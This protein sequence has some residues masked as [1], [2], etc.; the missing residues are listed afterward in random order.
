MYTDLIVDE[1]DPLPERLKE[2]MHK[3]ERTQGLERIRTKT[4]KAPDVL[5]FRVT[6]PPTEIMCCSEAP[7]RMFDER[8]EVRFAN[9]VFAP[10]ADDGHAVKDRE[11]EEEEAAEMEAEE[12]ENREDDA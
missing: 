1:E 3:M 9:H 10:S 2:L 4:K 5:L 8:I 12:A 6:S 7:C 11:G